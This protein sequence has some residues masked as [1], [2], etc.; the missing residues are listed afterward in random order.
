MEILTGIISKIMEHT[1]EPVGRQMGYQ[2]HYKKNFENLRSKWE[3]LDAAKDS[4]VDEDKRKDRKVR[5]DVQKWLTEANEMIQE[6]KKLLDDEDHAKTKCFCGVCPTL[7]SYHQ[8]SRKSVKLAKTIE[9][10]HDKKEFP[11]VSYNAPLEE[12]CATPSQNYMAFE[13]RISMVKEIME[14][15]KNIDTNMTGVY[16]LSGV[17]KTT[18]AQ[19][20]YRQATKRTYLMRWL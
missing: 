16:G 5:T 1:I 4:M 9:L 3:N 19:E 2:I 20:V 6:A 17:G 15:L 18:V 12:I 11:I 10:H 8:L 14:E 7:V 13:S